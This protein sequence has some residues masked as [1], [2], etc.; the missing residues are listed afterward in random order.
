M[1]SFDG[2]YAVLFS[3]QFRQQ[4]LVN[5]SHF[6]RRFHLMYGPEA[7]EQWHQTWVEPS[8]EVPDKQAWLGGID[9]ALVRGGKGFAV[10]QGPA[11]E[12]R[13]ARGA[14]GFELKVFDEQTVYD[15]VLRALASFA[16]PA[17]A[18]ADVHPEG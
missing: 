2:T 16:P 17:A 12:G 1:E 15:E 14:Q 9:D 8:A 6:A 13:F 11:Y 4:Q 7:S 18:V 3:R 10:Q 5:A